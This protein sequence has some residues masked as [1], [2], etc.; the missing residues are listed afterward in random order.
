MI[1]F[2]QIMSVKS[3]QVS[4]WNFVNYA[5]PVTVKNQTCPQFA[6]CSDYRYECN[7]GII[8]LAVGFFPQT[9]FDFLTIQ[10]RR[11]YFHIIQKV[12]LYSA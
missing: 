1:H 12:V 3:C 9:N 2:S 4:H 10:F 8:V 5:I 11:N 6:F 7:N